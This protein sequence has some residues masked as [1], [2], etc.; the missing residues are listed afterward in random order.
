[1]SKE[2]HIIHYLRWREVKTGVQV[3]TTHKQEEE[4]R[5]RQGGECGVSEYNIALT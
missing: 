2:L 3:G 5:K 4:E 1:M